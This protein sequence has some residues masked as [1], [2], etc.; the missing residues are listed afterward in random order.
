V[1]HITRYCIERIPSATASSISSLPEGFFRGSLCSP[2]P[3]GV[4]EPKPFATME[5]KMLCEPYRLTQQ[6]RSISCMTVP[7]DSSAVR[8][9][10]EVSLPTMHSFC[11]RCF[12]SLDDSTFTLLFAKALYCWF[13]SFFLKLDQVIVVISSLAFFFSVLMKEFFHF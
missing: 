4:S 8:E 11:S 7:W 3:V 13:T 10:F 6:A 12:A 1:Y 5:K 2:S 9:I